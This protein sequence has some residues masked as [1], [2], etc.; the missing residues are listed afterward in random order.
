MLARAESL[1]EGR[2]SDMKAHLDL[3]GQYRKDLGYHLPMGIYHF[4]A[5]KDVVAAKGSIQEARNLSRWDSIWAYSMAF[6][7]G[8]E[9][10][11]DGAYRVYRT[12]FNG[13]G[14]PTT[15]IECAVF[16]RRMLGA[17]PDKIQ[18]WYCL[19]L[20]YLFPYDDPAL[21]KES[22]LEFKR[23]ALREK[24]FLGQIQHVDSYLGKIDS[25]AR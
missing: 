13:G 14:A 9:G 10:N 1:D 17:E 19:G 22:F 6:L 24:K 5:N 8:Y 2:L 23:L 25:D 16:I 11:L 3:A 20:L 21:A 12:A 15:H 7:L 18:L 4:P